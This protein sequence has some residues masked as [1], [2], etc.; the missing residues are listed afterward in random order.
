ML[1]CFYLVFFCCCL[2]RDARW[3]WRSAE[4][5]VGSSS[6]RQLR[7]HHL[8]NFCVGKFCCKVKSVGFAALPCGT[9]NS[10]SIFHVAFAFYYYILWYLC[11]CVWVMQSNAKGI[12]RLP[13][14]MPNRLSVV[15]GTLWLSA[16]VYWYNN[17]IFFCNFLYFLFLRFFH[18][19]CDSSMFVK[20][21]EW[22]HVWKHFD[23]FLF[24]FDDCWVLKISFNFSISIGFSFGFAPFAT[25]FLCG[26]HGR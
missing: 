12:F 7:R 24:S 18:I 13:D 14:C 23:C 16:L 1:F 21:F 2:A 25:L 11:I 22:H 26:P 5:R 20:C 19:F 8:I 6:P 15:S 17:I 3:T 4:S 9:A 10:N